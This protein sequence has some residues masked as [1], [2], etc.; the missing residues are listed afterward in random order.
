MVNALAV[1]NRLATAF[2]VP[3][4][5]DHLV[6]DLGVDSFLEFFII[7]K[8][9]LYLDF[10]YVNVSLYLDPLGGN[11]PTF[12]HTVDDIVVAVEVMEQFS[13]TATASTP[14]GCT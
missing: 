14:R 10:W 12:T 7:E 13:K 3:R 8:V 1:D 5:E 6:A 2:I 4:F 11:E 9:T